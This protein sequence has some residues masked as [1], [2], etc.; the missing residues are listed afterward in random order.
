[1]FAFEVRK[2]RVKEL[3]DSNLIIFSV[4]AFIVSVL[5]LIPLLFTLN[6]YPNV[7]YGIGGAVLLLSATVLLGINFL[8]KVS[9]ILYM[10]IWICLLVCVCVCSCVYMWKWACVCV[11]ICVYMWKWTCV[12]VCICVYMWKWTCVCVCI[13]Y[14]YVEMDVCMCMYLCVYVKMDVCLCMYFCVYVEMDVCMCVHAHVLYMYH[15][16]DGVRN[17]V[18]ILFMTQNEC[19]YIVYNINI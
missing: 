4:Y 19:K 9:F 17:T 2:I 3:N 5:A 6:T 12:C 15:W 14:V 18:N 8:P 10:H 7:L 16:W 13:F 1:M 11:C